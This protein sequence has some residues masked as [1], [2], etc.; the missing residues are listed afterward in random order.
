MNPTCRPLPKI[1]SRLNRD[2]KDTIVKSFLVGLLLTMAIALVLFLIALPSP[3]RTEPLAVIT[4]NL[5]EL[6]ERQRLDISS[7]K[8]GNSNN[9]ESSIIAPLNISKDG[10]AFD[11]QVA[12]DSGAQGDAGVDPELFSNIPSSMGARCDRS[13]R[14]QR[15][16]ETGGDE[17]TD[18]AVTK[19]LRWLQGTQNGNG[20]WDKE[21]Q[22]SMTGLALL[23]Y[24]G[25]CETVQSEEFGDTVMSAIVYLTNIA[26]KHDGRI[27]TDYQETWAYDQSIASYAL[28]EAYIFSK[29]FHQEIP[30]LKKS[31]QQAI[32][33]IMRAQGLDDGWSYRYKND[34]RCDNSINA[35][36]LQA[37]KAA[38][39]TAL[40]FKGI[41]EAI[42]RCLKVVL[43]TRDQHG[44]FK[45]NYLITRSSPRSYLPL[46]G[47]ASLVIQ[48]HRDKKHPFL[49]P[50]IDHLYLHLK[51]RYAK[52][53][54]LYEH[55]YISQ[56]MMNEGSLA[57]DRYRQ[58]FIPR[59]LN[60]QRDEGYWT[61]LKPAKYSVGPIYDTALAALI[62]ETHFRFLPGTMKTRQ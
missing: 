37:L 13:Q 16:I 28:C 22:V 32:D 57:W 58:G 5:A 30:N 24:L 3:S 51:T 59:L 55:Y 33:F 2:R 14:L 47:P 17:E 56:V 49:R 19:A 41:D 9:T 21:H 38:K 50:A 29:A 26:M 15:L 23:A 34:A 45:Y 40:E 8:S 6:S 1:R 36:H 44:G 31:V 62:L 43:A 54:E 46:T 48:L 4:F 11:L 7:S 18:F 53:A 25:R 27:S 61:N 20:S 52:G 60:S 12:D 42:D 10:Q 35:W 39:A